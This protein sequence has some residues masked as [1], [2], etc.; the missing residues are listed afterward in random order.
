V[1]HRPARFG[2]GGIA[3]Y[4]DELVRAYARAFPQDTLELW[5][6]RLR[7]RPPG[8]AAPAP[9][10]HAR[11]HAGLLPSLA[12]AT[13]ARMGW[14]TDRLV[15]G[16]DVVH[17]TDYVTLPA[18]RAPVVATIHDV[19]F[20]ELPACYT[21]EMR[22]G[23]RL[24]TTRILRAA[25]RLLVPSERTRRGLSVH[26]GVAPERVDLVPHGVRRLP[27]AAPAGDLGD[28]L[29]F[30]GTLEPRKNLAR[31]LDAHARL[32]GRGLGARLVVAGPRGWK[33]EALM[34]RLAAGGDVRW[35]RSASP[36]RLAAL[37]R[38][39]I[40]VAYP[41]LGEG[42]GL[43]V[44]EAM[45]EG[46]AVLVGQDTS[47]ADLAGDAALA[48]DP[49]DVDAL[50]DALARLVEDDDLRARLGE[51]GRARAAPYTWEA[52]ARGTRETYLKACA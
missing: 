18:T 14:G 27:P 30:V 42:F 23:L 21:A 2:R 12:V 31:L 26:Y 15:G 48:V 11:H 13:L 9:L 38:G 25:R 52:A 35:E 7:G 50:A 45:S 3:V 37:Y 4:V 47:C 1:D 46:R 29:L 22:A 28:Y 20:E 10:A 6:H 49:R 36:E 44:L 39:A 34:R 5:S 43:P 24:A 33:D 40:A 17:W 8:L 51:A 16:A 32:R 19:L 41:S